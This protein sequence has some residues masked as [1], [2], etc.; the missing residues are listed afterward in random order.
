MSGEKMTIIIYGK[1]GSECQ[2]CGAAKM[3][4]EMQKQAYEYKLIGEDVSPDQLS[5]MAGQPIRSAPAIFK[6]DRYGQLTFIGGYQELRKHIAS[7]A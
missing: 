1:S 3:L 6:K 5:E 2:Q 4:C 7:L